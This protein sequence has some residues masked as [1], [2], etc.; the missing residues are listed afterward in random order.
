MSRK[1]KKEDWSGNTYWVDEKGNREYEKED[2]MGNKYRED[3][4]GNRSYEKESWTGRK[5][6]EDSKGKREYEKDSW[7]GGK[8]R[9]DEDGN[10]TYTRQ[11]WS[12]N[13]Y[14][15][16]DDDKG[17]CFLTTA[18]TRHAGLPDDCYELRTLR[19][20][21]DRY[22]K[23]LPNGAQL[24]NEYYKNSPKILSALFL[25]ESYKQE[26]SMIFK[27]II[28]AVGCIEVGDNEGALQQYKKIYLNL[29][30][31][32]CKEEG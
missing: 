31:K 16:K 28:K 6:I 19:D 3:S 20:F 21:R 25:T 26:L 32:Y 15:E 4:N 30:S 27:R 13:T 24:L 9:E 14:E 23:E 17:G 11:D 8:Y 10:R 5:Y 29:N 1:Y 22:I 18:C 7:G 12:G 2:I